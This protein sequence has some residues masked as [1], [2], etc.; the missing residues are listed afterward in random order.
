MAKVKDY[1]HRF[2]GLWRCDS[3]CRI[4]LYEGIG[5]YS[6]LVIG[7][8]T[9]IEE[10]EGTSITNW[11]EHLAM[12]IGVLHNLS[13]NRLI[14]IEHYQDRGCFIKDRPQF[15]EHFDRVTFDINERGE[16]VRPRWTRFNKPTVETM[17]G[18]PIGTPDRE[19]WDHMLNGI[20]EGSTRP[21]DKQSIEPRCEILS[22]AEVQ[23]ISNLL[24][25]I[26]Y[27]IWE[28]VCTRP[29]GWMPKMRKPTLP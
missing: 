11:A 7:I 8:A 2:K 23:Q 16:F 25:L 21:E 4:R 14:W 13:P 20:P 19:P 22:L 3:R 1:E 6:A 28:V 15:K 24:T 29:S 27:D 5:V 12:E 17:I 9:E 10:N 26:I 18:E